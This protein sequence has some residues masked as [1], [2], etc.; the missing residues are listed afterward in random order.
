MVSE[1]ISTV[2]IIVYFVFMHDSMALLCIRSS[3]KY[4]LPCKCTIRIL[5][6]LLLYEP[7]VVLL[8]CRI[9]LSL[10]RCQGLDDDISDGLWKV[11][12][13]NNKYALLLGQTVASVTIQLK[14]A[15]PS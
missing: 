8:L 10:R 15:L 7:T 13:V 6:L 12:S 1:T 9:M 5:P 11:H 2:R 14:I 4:G 3:R